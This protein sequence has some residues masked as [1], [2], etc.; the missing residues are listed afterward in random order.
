MPGRQKSGEPL[1]RHLAVVRLVRADPELG[2]LLKS[3]ANKSGRVRRS[4]DGSTLKSSS[5]DFP[6]LS[7]D[8]GKP[9]MVTGADTSGRSG[10]VVGPPQVV[11]VGWRGRI[12]TFDLLIQR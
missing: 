2:D 12:R 7:I 9:V 8:P 1:S 10:G 11:G 6:R 4:N 3:Q 5:P